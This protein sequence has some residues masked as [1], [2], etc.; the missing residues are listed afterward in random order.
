MNRRD[1]IRWAMLGAGCGPVVRAVAGAAPATPPSTPWWLAGNFAPVADEVDA[2]PLP[3]TGTLPTA[4]TGAYVR[5]GSNPARSNSPHWFFGDGMVHGVWFDNGVA[6]R[7]RNR[8]VR[9]TMYTEHADFGHGPPGGATNQSNVSA[10]WHGGRL[11]TSGEV[12]L[13]YELRAEDL[14]T[15]GPL[16]FGGRLTTSFTAH[17]KIDPVS[18][19]MHGFGYGFVPPFLTYFI[20]EPDGS[21]SHVQEVPIPASTMIH[22]F[23]ITERY[24]VFWD[25]PVVFDLAQAAAYINDPSSGAFPYQWRPDAGARIG[26]LPLAGGE[27]R[28]FDIDPCYVFHGVNAFDH[29]DTVVVDVCRLSSMFDGPQILGGELSLRRWTV[30]TVTGRVTDD[31]LGHGDRRVGDL[32]TRN[33]RHVGRP[34]RYGY[35]VENRPSTTTVDLG[36]VIKHDVV[37]DTR[38]S[39]DPGPGSYG[40]E[41]L[42]VADPDGTDE[43]HG[44]LVGTVYHQSTG[45]SELVILDATRV[46]D[47]PVA[48]VGLPQ[49]VPFGFHATWV[50]GVT[51]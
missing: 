3:V 11:L 14:S 37:T 16:D 10:I 51:G 13:P 44:H 40:G 22:D 31:V 15:V 27:A 50:P 18:G 12:G 29:G 38:T 17:P 23:A 30:N 45:S 21:M 9:T 24:A 28:W 33:P 26:L 7:Y 43:D 41:W 1:L 39:W 8:Y 46:A 36:G 48:R 6:R 32:P 20:V 47:G 35:L 42:F 5:N 2:A 25:L 4:L 34:Y 49:R 19:R